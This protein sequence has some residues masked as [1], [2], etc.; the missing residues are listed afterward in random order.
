M[1]VLLYT[2][3][4]L[5]LFSSFKTLHYILIFCC[6]IRYFP[7]TACIGIVAC[8]VC[9]K[10][11]PTTPPTNGPPRGLEGSACC[12]CDRHQPMRKGPRTGPRGTR[13]RLFAD[14]LVAGN[15]SGGG[16]WG[17]C[18]IWGLTDAVPWRRRVC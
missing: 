8:L 1:I 11:L 6:T 17:S 7:D 12:P 15:T 14:W 13:V 5:Q 18:N 4:N 2:I 10:R 9:C 3:I 16:G